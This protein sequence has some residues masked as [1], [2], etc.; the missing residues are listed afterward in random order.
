MRIIGKVYLFIIRL[1]RRIRELM[2]RPLFGSYGRNFRFDPDGTYT[3][4]NIF[5]G[6]NVNLRMHPILVVFRSTI[7]I[8]NNVIFGPEITIRDG[9]HRFD[10]VGRYIESVTDEEKRPEGD[11]GVTIQDDVWV[12]TKAII[13]SGAKI[14]RGAIILAGAIV[15]NR[16][17]PY[18]IAAGAPAQIIRFSWDVDTI[19]KHEKILYQQ[20]DRYSR[21]E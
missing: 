8:L 10:L 17:P 21:S 19:L 6:D 18:V 16:I 5:V 14:G 13:L 15:T 4:E 2:L 3:F 12:G 7:K 11:L 20:N 1:S 9:N